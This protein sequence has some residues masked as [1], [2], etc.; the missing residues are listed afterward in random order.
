MT[1][2]YKIIFT[3]RKSVNIA[4]DRKANI[5]VRAPKHLS[6]KKLIA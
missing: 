2:D 3:E 5:I 6:K 4:I 1:I